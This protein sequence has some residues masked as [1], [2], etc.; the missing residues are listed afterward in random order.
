MPDVVGKKEAEA[1]STLEGAGLRAEV[2]EEESEDEDPGTVL[3]QDPASGE[4]DK[5]SAVKLVVAEAPPEVD[6]PDVVDQERDAARQ[7]L[8]DAGFEV[9][10]REETVDTIDQDGI[11]IDQDPAGGEQL[12]KGS[13]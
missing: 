10:V 11:V 12:R 4:L 5:G 6:V 1:R 3:R 13:R 9:R 2:T 7:A 8:R